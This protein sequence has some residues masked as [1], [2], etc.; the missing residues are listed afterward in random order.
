MFLDERNL[1]VICFWTTI[2]EKSFWHLVGREHA[3][4]FFGKILHINKK[5][6]QPV[7]LNNGTV[8]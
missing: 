5:S 3:Y 1:C 7:I 4:E 6:A 8:I 2:G